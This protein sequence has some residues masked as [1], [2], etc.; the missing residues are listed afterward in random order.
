MF[1]PNCS[2]RSLY[3]HWPFCPY[4]CNFCPFVAISGHEN[5]FEKYHQAL[6]REITEHISSQQLLEPLETVFMG[7]G[8]PSIYPVS[9]LLDMLGI[10][11]N[12]VGFSPDIEITIEVNPGTVTQEKLEAWYNGGIN[13]LSIGVQS[14]NDAVLKSLNRHQKFEDVLRLLKDAQKI[15]S[16]ISVDL[17]VGLPGVSDLEW[18]ELVN[19]VISWPIMHVS[20]YFL[21]VHEDTPLY[22][23]VK[24]QKIQL[25]SDDTVV[26]LYNWTRE[27]FESAGFYQYEISN[28]ARTGFQ[29]KHNTVYWDRK[30]YKGVGLGACSFDGESRFQNEKNLLKYIDNLENNSSVIVFSEKLTSKQIWL[31]KL[32]LGLRQSAGISLDSIILEL[33]EREEI[34]LRRTI[35]MLVQE[36]FVCLSKPDYLKL[37]PEG[38]VLSNEIIV[39]LSDI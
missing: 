35:D 17:I 34:N 20:L 2:P 36:K 31:E 9:L 18:K 37:T 32:M 11:N 22:F 3:V 24:Q 7:G 8:T 28:F 29:S 5:Y 26:D 10:L 38:L 27:K 16:N 1:S 19:H 23:G 4:K 30:P 12:R 33:S 14:K 13:R 21:T 25:P 6:L 39:K 15:F